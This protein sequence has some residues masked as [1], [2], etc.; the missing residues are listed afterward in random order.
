MRNGNKIKVLLSALLILSYV[1]GYG[2]VD[3]EI[4]KVAP[5]IH[6]VVVETAVV[7]ELESEKE[8]VPEVKESKDTVDLTSTLGFPENKRPMKSR[9]N[10]TIY[11]VLLICLIS[12]VMG[13]ASLFRKSSD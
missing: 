2:D 5:E 7:E 8:E 6:E 12:I 13:I 9:K 11:A 4:K 1:P 10:L 3:E